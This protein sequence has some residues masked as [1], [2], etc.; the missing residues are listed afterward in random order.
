GLSLLLV[1]FLQ[2]L[3]L[4]KNHPVPTTVFRAG[5]P[6]N[7]LGSPQLQNSENYINV[8][9][10]TKHTACKQASMQTNK[11]ANKQ[12][13]KQASKQTSKHAASR[14]CRAALRAFG[15]R[16]LTTQRRDNRLNNKNLSKFSGNFAYSATLI[17]MN[18]RSYDREIIASKLTYW[19]KQN[20]ISR[21]SSILKWTRYEIDTPNTKLHIAPLS[22]L[23]V[24]S[25]FYDLND[26]MRFKAE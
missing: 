25:C 24:S 13:S 23:R 3:L 2:R 6:V 1:L 21:T 26:I 5:A 9:H 12:A 7:P 10:A 20:D 4:T 22:N 18:G 19:T 11:Q 16:R 17:Y 15:R 8:E 14:I